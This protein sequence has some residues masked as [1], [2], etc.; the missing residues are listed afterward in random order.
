MALQVYNFTIQD[1]GVIADLGTEDDAFVGVEGFLNSFD[2]IVIVG[3]GSGHEV[4]V[5]GD[6]IGHLSGM[7]LG[8]SAS[9]DFD[10]RLT[11][12]EDAT[13]AGATFSGAVIYGNNSLVRNDGQLGGVGNGVAMYGDDLGTRS[14]LI[15]NGVIVN[16]SGSGAAVYRNGHE[17]F[18]FINRGNVIAQSGVAYDGSD[19]DAV[20]KII[21]SG[22]L[23][24]DV[25]FGTG[26]DVYNGVGGRMTGVVSGDEG[27]D[28]LIGGNR[29]DTFSGDAGRD[30]LQGGRGADEFIYHLMNDTHVDRSGRD[31]IKDFR[32]SQGDTILLEELDAVIGGADDAF[33][34]IGKD[35][36][37][38]MPGELRYYFEGKKTFIEGTVDSDGVADFAIELKG[39]IRLT[40]DDFVL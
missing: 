15:N 9:L 28:R 39:R 40:E 32:L 17:D 19:P 8:D 21:N 33:T 18:L 1:N 5:R 2:D 30:I 26:D 10:Q 16:D 34:F 14:R 36:F 7:T 25:I 23:G 6:V 38:N 12:G 35:N 4:T 3:T 27:N 29:S 37:S 31:L 24:G 22:R 11:I 13:V 20:Q